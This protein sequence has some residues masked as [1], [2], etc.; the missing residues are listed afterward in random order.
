MAISGDG[1]ESIRSGDV[2]G[3]GSVYD[4]SGNLVTRAGESVLRTV[5]G[6]EADVRSPWRRILPKMV[7]T[8]YRGQ[9]RSTLYVTSQRIV[10]IREVDAWREVSGDMTLLGMP[11]AVAKEAK[12]Q[13]LKA[14]GAREFCEILPQRLALVS[15]KKYLKRGSMLEMRLR[16]SAGRQ[17]GVSLWKSSGKDDETLAL[18]ESRFNR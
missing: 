12:L 10:L 15:S 13:G 16:D 17:F 8:G 4:L 9:S 3:R 7:F 2:E 6:W 18:L 11:D 14:A 5:K 1:T